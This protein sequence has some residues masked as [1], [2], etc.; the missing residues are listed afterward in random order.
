MQGIPGRGKREIASYLVGKRGYVLFDDVPFGHYTL[1][2]ARDG[3]MLGDYLFEI[4][5][6]R[7]GKK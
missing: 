5:E 4:K 6:T 2:L 7:Y 1:T 3:E